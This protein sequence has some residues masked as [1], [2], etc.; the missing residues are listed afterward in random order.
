MTTPRMA[1]FGSSLVSSYWNG[2]ATYYRGII[3]A[4]DRLGWD[5][6]FFESDAYDRQTHRD[7][8]DPGWATVVVYAAEDASVVRRL[9]TSL[10]RFDVLVKASGV[11]VFD[12]L[13]E[14]GLL[15][16]RRS[17][18]LC[19]FWDVDA[20]ATL[21]RLHADPADPFRTCVPRYD[22]ILTY[23]GGAPVVSAYAALGARHCVPV[24][25]GLDPD[26]HHPVEPDP[27]FAWDI[28]LLVNRLPDREARIEEFFFRPAAQLA[29]RRFLLGGSGWG[30]KLMPDN[31]TW[32]GHVPTADHNAFNS[33][34]TAVLSVNRESMARIGHSPATR[35]FEAAG[36]GACI[37]SDAWAGLEQFFEPGREILTVDGADDVTACVDALDQRLA[38]AVGQAALRRVLQEHTYDRRAQD[39]QIAMGVMAAS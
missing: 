36:A 37:I 7:I 14:D 6:T 32:L 25:N 28:A 1:F 27:R 33:S 29:S 24:Y 11:G 12:D 38:R 16:V 21:E 3:R 17:H 4:L 31:V 30:D 39:V 15:E 5:I 35:I 10:D 2:A 8:D 34:P 13:L 20:P 23:G 19:V 26:T 9:M 22:L 18:Q